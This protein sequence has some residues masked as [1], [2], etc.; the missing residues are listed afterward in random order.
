MRR[1]FSGP[2][3]RKR[4]HLRE[5]LAA[6]ERWRRARLRRTCITRG[7]SYEAN[8]TV[9]IGPRCPAC[10]TLLANGGDRDLELGAGD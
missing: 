1:G 6:V 4:S 10:V 8:D 3:V 5:L 7:A 9:R 2:T